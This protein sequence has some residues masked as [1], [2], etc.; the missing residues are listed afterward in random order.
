MWV[1]VWSDMSQTKQQEAIVAWEKE[2]RLRDKCREKYK[3]VEQIPKPEEQ[4]YNFL[5]KEMLEKYG[6]KKHPA[7]P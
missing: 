1:E 2:K 6:D 3:L 5:I 4:E 7:M